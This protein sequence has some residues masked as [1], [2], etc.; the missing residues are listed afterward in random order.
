MNRAIKVF[1]DRKDQGLIAAITFIIFALG[2]SSCKEKKLPDEKV[3]VKAPEKMDDKVKEL[4]KSFIEY[5]VSENGRME[6]STVLYQLP[7]LADLYKQ[8]T[9]A[10]QWSSSQKWLAQG[11]SLLSFIENAKLYGLFPGDYHSH[12]LAILKKIFAADAFKDKETQDA[13]SW[14][15]ADLMLSDAL[16]SIFH[17]IKLG[18]LPNDSITLRKDSVL[19]EEFIS[20]KFNAAASGLSLNVIMSTLEPKYKGYREL[21]AAVSI[22]LDSAD[23]NPITPIVFPNK[24][25]DELK[26]AV[27]K[28]L[29][30]TGYIDSLNAQPDSMR[31]AGVL[32][33]Y[34]KNNRLTIDGKIGSQT[35]RMLNLSDAE[36][37]DR[38][39]ITMDRYKMLSDSFPEKYIWVNIPSY[40][41]KLMNRDTLILNSKVVVGKP[42]TRTPVLTSAVSE[43]IT[44]PQWTIPESIVEKEIIPGMKKDTGYLRKKGYMILNYKNEEIS[45]DSV[46]W[47]KYEKKIPYKVIQGS[48]DDNALGVLKFNFPNK[49]SVY[50]HDTNQRYFFG[51]DI[52]ALSHGCVRVQEWEKMA[53][54]IMNNQVD[55][56]VKK[57]KPN[58][59]TLDSMTHWL[60]IKEKHS[61]PLRKRIPVYIR[62]FTCEAN[63]GLITFFEDIYEEDKK[64]IE[65]LFANKKNGE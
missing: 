9:F 34:Q 21:K 48:G 2:F 39:A 64:M 25:R 17:D 65:L 41:L 24:N 7:I 10:P 38:I 45:P 40:S 44:Y 5:S 36:K 61:I 37:F 50:L 55:S 23:F 46:N 12:Q 52:R 20:S 59:I 47:A 28:R 43:I 19:S 56:N 63:D 15:R 8:K 54:Y 33:K 60:V 27:V 6:D 51:Q 4:I 32:K 26:A 13:A 62:Y 3:I 31:L 29:F 14:A 18:R 58:E 53:Y 42:I 11:D 57:K 35:I 30:E 16:V 22:F 49:Y 1:F